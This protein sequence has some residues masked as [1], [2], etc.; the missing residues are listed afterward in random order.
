MVKRKDNGHVGL[1]AIFPVVDAVLWHGDDAL[2]DRDSR[3][4]GVGHSQTHDPWERPLGY[5]R[6]INRNSREEACSWGDNCP[7]VRGVTTDTPKK[8]RESLMASSLY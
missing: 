5:G 4:R 6:N 1:S 7:A 2:H 8:Q 3:S